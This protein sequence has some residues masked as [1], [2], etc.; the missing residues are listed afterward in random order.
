MTI[1]DDFIIR[2]KALSKSYQ[3]LLF[4][5]LSFSLKEREIISVIGPSGCGKTT[6]FNIV[7]GLESP[8]DGV[9]EKK[10][11][12]KDIAYVFQD[13]ILLPW[14]NLF[15]N[16][17]LPLKMIKNNVCEQDVKDIVAKVGLIDSLIEY[18]QNMSGGMK[19]RAAIAC[20]LIRKPKLLILDEP[21]SGLDFV[22]KAN[23]LSLLQNLVLNDGLAVMISSHSI[24]DALIISS[25]VLM[26]PKEDCNKV[27]CLSVNL[28]Y[29]RSLSEDIHEYESKIISYYQ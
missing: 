23:I 14:L 5:G 13:S 20:A 15:Q 19:R 1:S 10:I 28:D 18:P 24:Y 8:D 25:K 26:F 16:V 22:A 7:S 29:P 2:V 11:S 9:V 27:E 12:T 6:F 4:S 3:K 21:M 17:Q